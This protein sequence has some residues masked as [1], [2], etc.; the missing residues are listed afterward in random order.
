MC[1][2]ERSQGLN[3]LLFK[4]KTVSSWLLVIYVKLMSGDPKDNSDSSRPT[5]ND[6]FTNYLAIFS[7]YNYLQSKES[8]EF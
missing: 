3:A 2:R 4:L 1:I 5:T 6:Y 7:L 8:T